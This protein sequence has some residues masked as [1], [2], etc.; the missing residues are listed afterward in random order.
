MPS[1][2]IQ[3]TKYVNPYNKDQNFMIYKLTMEDLQLD[4]RPKV[5]LFNQLNY[6]YF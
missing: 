2:K 5:I 3:K 6:D 4:A 1:D